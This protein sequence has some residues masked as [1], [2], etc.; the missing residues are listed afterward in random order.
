[1]SRRTFA[2]MCAEV[3]TRTANR[4]DITEAQRMQFVTDGYLSVANEFWHTQLQGYTTAVISAATDSG[5]PVATDL[6][7]PELVKDLT[8]GR[9][10]VP[11][12]KDQIESGTK[13]AGDP[14][15]YYWWGNAFYLNAK[16]T[17]EHTLGLWYYKEPAEPDSTDVSVLDRIFDP[18]IVMT[19]AILAL[20]SVRDF[21]EAH[22]QE[23]QLQNYLAHKNLP[24]HRAKLDDKSS[25]I[26]VRIR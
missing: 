25:G 8:S 17:T 1:V 12:Q 22:I 10:L 15:K 11:G 14:S 13:P 16:P 24:Y 21:A 3:L 19:A 7:W 26:R 23:V 9:I 20:Q 18:V 2:D 5:T 6:W 4:T